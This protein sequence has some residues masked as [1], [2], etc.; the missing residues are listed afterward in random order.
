[1]TGPVGVLHVHSD[2]SRDGL[3]SLEALRTFALDRGIAFV[4]LT[5]HAEDF[6]RA[7][8]EEYLIRCR[9]VSAGGPLLFPGLEFRFAGFP[10]LHLLALGLRAWME[11]ATPLDFLAQ[12]SGNAEF[13]IVA[14]PLLCRYEIPEGIG[15]GIDAIEV[16]NAAYNTRWLPDPR[17]IALLQQLR[18]QRPAIVGVAGLD[19]HDA[20]NDRETRVVLHQGDPR[21]PWETLRAG[22]FENRG[23]T[24]RF[25]PRMEWAPWRLA[26][27]RGARWGLDRVERVQDRLVRRLRRARSGRR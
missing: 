15:A 23:R 24:L 17:A 22:R 4:C 21:N 13:T 27:L 11:P 12:A 8:F 3:D 26:L 7:K 2:Y 6:D 16:W 25:D 14:H 9:E 1:M 5:D 18:R 10:G 20:S 19:Q